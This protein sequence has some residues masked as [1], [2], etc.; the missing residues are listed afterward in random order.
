LTFILKYFLLVCFNE[1][2]YHHA[3]RILLICRRFYFA[4]D[5]DGG[6]LS[7]IHLND[8][9]GDAQ[10]WRL[11]EFWDFVYNSQVSS[12]ETT[13]IFPTIALICQSLL[14]LSVPLDYSTMIAIN[15]CTAAGLSESD[16]E[17]LLTLLNNLAKGN[18]LYGKQM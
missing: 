6:L 10:I 14:S 4:Q 3:H 9:L 2:D 16:V 7:V 11:T 15:L 8:V 12:Q 1:K 13:G 18:A 5:G 17:D